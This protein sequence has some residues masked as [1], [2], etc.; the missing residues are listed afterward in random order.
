MNNQK[1]RTK[2][3]V[4]FYF[5]IGALT[6][7]KV[8]SPVKSILPLIQIHKATNLH[9]SDKTYFSRFFYDKNSLVPGGRVELPLS[10]KNR[11]LSPARLPVPPSGR[12]LPFNFKQ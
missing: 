8:K 5:L 7:V 3:M 2:I 12:R 6:I 1:K 11:I 9:L 10:L 4:T